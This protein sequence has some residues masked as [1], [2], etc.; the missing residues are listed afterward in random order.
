MAKIREEEIIDRWSTLIED[1]NGRGKEI[2]RLTKE[3][4]DALAVPNIELAQKEI[5]PSLMKKLKGKSRIFLVV[6]NKYLEGYLMYIGAADYGKQLS[7]SWYLTL[8]PSGLARLLS[9]LP[10]WLQI[11]FFPL[12]IPLAIYNTFRKKKSVSPADMDLFDLEELTA[13]VSTVHHALMAATKQVS[14]SVGFD[15][16]KV[17]Q[18]S[19]GFLNIS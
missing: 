17:D 7:V 6:R 10:W 12:F 8:E 9:K 16:T 3:N 13:Y 18:K 1:A 15:F 14:E 19:K 2:F 5:S 4:L 11:L